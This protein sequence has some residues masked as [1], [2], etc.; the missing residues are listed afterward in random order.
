MKRFLALLLPLFLCIPQTNSFAAPKKLCDEESQ[1]VKA[2][3]SFSKKLFNEVKKIV[4]KP[5]NWASCHK[6]QLAFCALTAS[7]LI[8]TYY[9]FTLGDASLLET[10]SLH[11]CNGNDQGIFDIHAC[12]HY[13]KSCVD[14]SSLEHFLTDAQEQL[15]DLWEQIPD[16][17]EF[18]STL[19]RIWSMLQNDECHIHDE[20]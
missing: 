9:L 15:A 13:M 7:A 11:P 19:E 8:T 3:P 1:T 4:T 2:L 10:S 6:K 20:L 14:A 16:S 5:I 12:M 18:Y 17:E